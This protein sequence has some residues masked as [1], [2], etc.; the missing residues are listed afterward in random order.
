MKLLSIPTIG[1]GNRGGDRVTIELANHFANDGHEVNILF[2][3]GTNKTNFPINPKVNLIEYGLK[4]K[5]IEDISSIIRTLFLFFVIPKSDVVLANYYLTAL[6]ILF[7]HI[8]QP[9]TKIYYII[10]AYEPFSF[11]KAE[12]TYP[13]LKQWLAERTYTFGFTHICVSNWIKAKVDKFAK[14]PAKVFSPGIN[15]DSF[16]LNKPPNNFRFENALLAFPSNDEAKGWNDFLKAIPIILEEFPDLQIIASS[17]DL[18]PIHHTNIRPVQPNNDEELA[19]L[20]HSASIYVHPAWWE[21]CPLAPLEAMACGTPVV[22]AKSEGIMEYAH[23]LENCYLVNVNDPLDLAKGIIHL[24]K[25]Q[26]L[27]EKISMNGLKT[28]NNYTWKNMYDQVKNIISI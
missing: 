2:P 15:H 21:G 22:A 14:I 6:P 24:L 11:G 10:Q 18:F 23:H 7:H 16:N 4:I 3:K 17:K 8:I 1:I 27:R 26:E 12:K 20:Y 9:K 25:D 5:Q 28:V 19:E 13:K